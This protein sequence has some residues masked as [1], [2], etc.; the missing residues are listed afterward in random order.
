VSESSK[1]T[2]VFPS[3]EQIPAE[4]RERPQWIG[5]RYKWNGHE[6]KKPPCSAVTGLEKG[7]P[8]SG[9][10]F[11]EAM[12]G[13]ARLKLDGI[14]RLLDGLVGIDFDDCVADGKVHETVLSWLKWFGEG[15][16]E[17]SVSGTGV[18][19]ICRGK[20]AKALTAT[21][22]PDSDGATVE[23]YSSGHYF[24]MTGKRLG[25]SVTVGD[26]QGGVDKLLAL[27]D[28]GETGTEDRRPM[29]RST[30]RKL[31]ADN[32]AALLNA[33]HGE[34]NAQLNN[35]S[36]FAGRAFAGGM[37]D[38][39]EETV[40]AELL[41]IVTREW[42]NPHDEPGA[43]ATID[44]GWSSGTSQP[45]ALRGSEGIVTNPGNLQEMTESAERVLHSMGL[46]YFERNGE[47]VHTVYGRDVAA[48]KGFRR[49]EDSVVIARASHQTI[50]LDLDRRA[51]FVTVSK[52][53]E[54]TCQVPKTLPGFITNRVATAPREVPFQT[55]DV[56]TGSPVLLPSGQVSQNPFAEGVLFVSG[57]R[58]RFP[59][60]PE[61]PT[62]ADGHAAMAQFWEVFKGFP[63][64]DPGEQNDPAKTASYSVALAGALSLVARPYLGIRAVPI[65]VTSAS[66]A[67]SGKT[68]IVEAVSGAMLGYKPTAVHFTDEEELGKHLQ[69]IMRA[70]DRAVLLDNVERTLQSSK[71]CILITGGVLRDRVLGLSEDVVLKNY[72]VLFATGNN[73]VVGGDLAVRALRCDIDANTERPESRRF[74]FDPVARAIDRHPQL[75][76]AAVTALRAY[77]LAGAPWVPGRAKWGGFEAWDL[78]VSG[79]LVWLGFADP[80]KARARIIDADPIRS[81]NVDI[82]DAWFER[83]KD[84]PVT[85]AEIRRD[86]SD[87]TDALMKDGRWDGMHASWLLRR[88]EGKICEGYRLVRLEGRSRFRVVKADLLG[89]G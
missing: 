57:N 66:T 18:H 59:P 52:G 62:K 23:I 84:G 79:C 7:W 51:T 86:E 80:V 53:E 38:D 34:G 56:V 82:L 54:K 61:S 50:V 58:H 40:K 60:A 73:I 65:F 3:A 1:P 68:K 67:R 17:L 11:D 15:Y 88:L 74:D 76:V 55:L 26:C 5:F 75:V 78:L 37:F 21:P 64:V 4:L 41:R 9:V 33:N 70:G 19:V 45:L 81:A 89:Q 31:H 2:P 16:T 35:A 69:P 30:A 63:F 72:A 14:G 29:S 12:S 49:D 22:L 43:R 32:L 85:L 48:E 83:Y 44:S 24:T 71:L 20:I 39:S 46:K 8:E 47:L 25:D 6:W 42:K 77:L 36:F 27:L 28:A 10:T 87:V 13:V